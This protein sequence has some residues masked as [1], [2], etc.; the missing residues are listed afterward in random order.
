MGSSPHPYQTA[1]SDGAGQ[2]W[3][4]GAD[5]TGA[6]VVVDGVTFV[7][8]YLPTTSADRFY[9]LK[10][11]ALL[12]RYRQLRDVIEDGNVVELWTW[13]GSP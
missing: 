1:M 10:P 11:R 2:A 12:E 13:T 8:G 4:F 5:E 7:L 6:E 9:L 3:T